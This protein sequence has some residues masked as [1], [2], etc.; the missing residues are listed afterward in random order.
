MARGEIRSD[1][2]HYRRD[3]SEETPP[4]K[5]LLFIGPSPSRITPDQN[6]DFGFEEPITR[7]DT[8]AFHLQLLRV[9]IYEPAPVIIE[10][11]GLATLL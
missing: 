7:M 9:S 4:V 5:H 3:Y 8:A 11:A 1:K 6:I 10:R 2:R